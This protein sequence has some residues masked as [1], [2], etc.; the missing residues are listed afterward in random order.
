MNSMV[1]YWRIP[2]ELYQYNIIFQLSLSFT[3]SLLYNF[4]LKY[5]LK[6]ILDIILLYNYIKTIIEGRTNEYW[7]I[8]FYIFNPQSQY[9]SV[10][11]GVN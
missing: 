1:N 4:I 9:S 5:N 7:Y 11:N 3:K 8:S 10:S 6:T 2:T